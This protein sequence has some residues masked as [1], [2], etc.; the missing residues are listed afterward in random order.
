[1]ATA[2]KVFS[3]GFYKAARKVV[4]FLPMRHRIQRDQGFLESILRAK[5]LW[6]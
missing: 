4:P 3:F 2:L 1:M 5:D 6:R